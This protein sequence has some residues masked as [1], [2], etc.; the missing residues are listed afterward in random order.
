MHISI[1]LLVLAALLP[2]FVSCRDR[3]S[4][5]RCVCSGSGGSGGGGGGGGGGVGGR[6]SGE[7][8]RISID[9]AMRVGMMRLR[10]GELGDT[11]E[12]AG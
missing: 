1:T 8:L 11:F 10:G 12:E 9:E 4:L 3:Q 6:G 5:S 2:C 7:I